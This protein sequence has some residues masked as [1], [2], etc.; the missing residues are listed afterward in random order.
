MLRISVKSLT[1]LVFALTGALM[2][3][4]TLPS[5]SPSHGAEKAQ[6]E[7]VV[8]TSNPNLPAITI[9][10]TSSTGN[11]LVPST[12]SA[13]NPSSSLDAPSQEQ[14]KMDHLTTLFDNVVQPLLVPVL[15]IAALD[16]VKILGWNL[17]TV[18]FVPPSP[19]S[20]QPR[21]PFKLDRLLCQP[22]LRGEVGSF[23]SLDLQSPTASVR[24][25][26]LWELANNAAKDAVRVEEIQSW[27]MEWTAMKFSISVVKV[28]EVAV[29]GMRG[30]ADVDQVEWV[31]SVEGVRVLPVRRLSFSS[32]PK[33]RPR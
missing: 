25:R 23:S 27:P 2:N 30:L 16:D 5:S 15:A 20:A 13:T 21:E 31:R 29:R 22:F 18:I 33:R 1:S 9:T 10:A 24:E 6:E 32:S 4:A 26:G 12:S 14:I 8:K 7:F 11:V 17:L 28:F 19:P 3:S